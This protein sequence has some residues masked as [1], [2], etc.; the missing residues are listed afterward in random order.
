MKTT[1]N[2]EDGVYIGKVRPRYA[3]SK[4]EL[5]AYSRRPFQEWTGHFKPAFPATMVG[6]DDISGFLQDVN[7]PQACFQGRAVVSQFYC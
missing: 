5:Y 1:P 6:E 3:G 4:G 2:P 7:C